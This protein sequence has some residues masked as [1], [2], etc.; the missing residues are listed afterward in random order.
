MGAMNEDLT[1]REGA[2]GSGR[3]WR[4]IF[5]DIARGSEAALGEIY[6]AAARPVFGLALWRTGSTDEACDVVQELFVR[7]AEQGT[8]LAKVRKPRAWLFA[9][10]HRI[11]VDVARRR[12]R[13]EPLERCALLEAATGDAGRAVDAARAGTLLARLSA[14][15]REAVYLRHYADCTFAEIGQVTGVPTFTA[16]SRYRLGIA[17]LRRMMEGER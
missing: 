17:K 13:S 11:A 8:K 15:Q 3:P 14:A 12:G 7:L 1:L 2:K 10:A 5:L 4:E 6:D 16:A 9:V